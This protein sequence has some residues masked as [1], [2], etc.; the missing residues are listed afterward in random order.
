METTL[1]LRSVVL[2]EL[3]WA[4]QH[5]GLLGVVP[6]SFHE[7]MRGVRVL[8]HQDVANLVRQDMTQDCRSKLTFL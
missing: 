7:P 2:G 1:H 4:I 6:E 3:H 8:A 5:F